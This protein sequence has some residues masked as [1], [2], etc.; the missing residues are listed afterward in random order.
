MISELSPNINK[1]SDLFKEK[2]L[3]VREAQ[4]AKRASAQFA[5]S[6]DADIISYV[7][8]KNLKRSSE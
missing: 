4:R 3:K 6:P 5:E 1:E 2:I 8:L 7:H